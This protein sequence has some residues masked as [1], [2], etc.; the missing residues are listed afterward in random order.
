MK[1]QS[2]LVSTAGSYS[3]ALVHQL[4]QLGK[5]F[6]LDTIVYVLRLLCQYKFTI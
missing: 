2:K 5:K 6:T 1:L 4:N 3:V